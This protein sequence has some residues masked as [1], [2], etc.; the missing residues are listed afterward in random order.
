M[1]SRID[2]RSLQASS[3]AGFGIF[4]PRTKGQSSSDRVVI[5]VRRVAR[6]RREKWPDEYDDVEGP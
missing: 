1:S 3:L 4:V 5:S 2:R 6:P